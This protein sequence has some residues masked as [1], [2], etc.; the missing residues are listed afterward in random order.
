MIYQEKKNNFLMLLSLEVLREGPRND[1][2]PLDLQH[3]LGRAVGPLGLGSLGKYS[4]VGQPLTALSV[5]IFGRDSRCVLMDKKVECSRFP[6]NR[7]QF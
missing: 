7:G 4:F 2:G 3:H 1:F 6:R 5:L